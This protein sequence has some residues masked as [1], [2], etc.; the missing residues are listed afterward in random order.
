MA[1]ALET[2][3]QEIFSRH[4]REKSSPRVS[5]YASKKISQFSNAS[6]EK[7]LILVGDFD[8]AWATRLEL[9][10]S[11]EIKDHIGS[12]VGNRHN[13]AHGRPNEVSIARLRDWRKSLDALIQ[14]LLNM[15]VG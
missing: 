3:M 5:A 8:V 10:W 9:F 4:C 1:G 2:A 6:P 12:I 13:I 15:V 11:D 7:I 14:E